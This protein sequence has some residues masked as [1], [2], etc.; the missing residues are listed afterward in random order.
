MAEATDISRGADIV[1]PI[2]QRVANS[3]SATVYVPV[4]QMEGYDPDKPVEELLPDE[5]RKSLAMDHGIHAVFD[6]V[7]HAWAF[8][9]GVPEEVMQV[10]RGEQPLE[11]GSAF[12]D[13]PSASDITPP[14]APLPEVVEVPAG[15]KTPVLGAAQAANPPTVVTEGQPERTNPVEATPAAVNPVVLPQ[16]DQTGVANTDAVREQ[17]ERA[18]EGAAPETPQGS[19][20]VNNPENPAQG[21]QIQQ[22]P[23]QQPPELGGTH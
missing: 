13:L 4:E 6:V 8:T 18:R 22:P 16:Q 14:G 15:E 21:E 20:P 19:Q 9:R 11:G 17:Q 23:Y 5:H 12:G 7:R 2:R 3:Q 10:H 1:D